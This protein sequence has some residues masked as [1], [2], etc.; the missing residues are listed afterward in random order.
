V[1]IKQV[2]KFK[3]QNVFKEKTVYLKEEN[4][5]VHVMSE[6]KKPELFNK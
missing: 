6:G 2:K 1:K 3:T 4:L 5:T